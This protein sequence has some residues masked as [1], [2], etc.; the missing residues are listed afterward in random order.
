MAFLAACRENGC[1]WG[2]LFTVLATCGLRISEALGLTWADVDLST[3]VLRVE[4]SL[5]WIGA[6]Y[7]IGPVKTAA[8]CRMISI[9]EL[10]VRALDALAG[11]DER[12]PD[13]AVFRS[14]HGN[15]PRYDQLHKPLS[16]VCVQAG[17]PR[18][19][20]HGLRHVAAALSY[21]ATGDALAVQRRL[22]HTK[23]TTTLGIY[24]YLMTSD[25]DTAAAVDSLLDLPD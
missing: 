22:G 12:L 14:I 15:P 7:Q 4:R 19:N 17:V 5:V 3:R 20:V 9:P 8:G 23:V 25:Q 11:K 24:A 10:G 21:K 18:L 13:R 6:E 2:P 1:R 16:K